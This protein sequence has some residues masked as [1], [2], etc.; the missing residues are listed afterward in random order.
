MLIQTDVAA[1]KNFILAEG[2]DFQH[3]MFGQIYQY[4]RQ[5]VKR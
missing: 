2:K 1:R 3:K 5:K 4:Y